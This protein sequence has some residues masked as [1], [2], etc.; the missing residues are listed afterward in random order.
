[1]MHLQFSMQKVGLVAP[2][3]KI[4]EYIIHA[5]FSPKTKFAIFLLLVHLFIYLISKIFKHYA[6]EIRRWV[7]KSLSLDIVYGFG[8]YPSS[9]NLITSSLKCE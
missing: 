3:L 6:A 5:M 8:N 9:V 7:L 1:M 4:K 2:T